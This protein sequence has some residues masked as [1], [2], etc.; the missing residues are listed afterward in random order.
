MI[1]LGTGVGSGIVVNGQLVYGHD[2]FAGE[3]GHVIVDPDGRQCGCGRKGCLET[4]CSATGVARTA[5][6]FLV[7][8]S[9]P[10]LL[11]NIPAE[12]IQSKDVYDAA[13]KGDQLALVIFAF[14][15]EVLGKA[16]ANFVAFSSPEAIVLFGGLAKSGDYI[17]KPIQ[18]AMEDNIL[19]IYAGKTKLLL[20]QLKDADAAVLGASALGWEVREVTI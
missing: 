6:E 17:M 3:L 20:S 4:Y 5:R 15:G 9:E 7:K 13:V 18:K 11:R 16:L 12:E 8:R 19:K 2:G 10:S 1:T 14:T